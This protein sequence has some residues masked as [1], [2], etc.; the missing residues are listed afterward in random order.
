MVKLKDLINE[1]NG[2]IYH[3]TPT[4]QGYLGI[5]KNGLQPNKVDPN[6]YKNSK[7]FTPIKN[8][9][10]LTKEFGNA[11]RYSFMSNGSDDEYIDYLTFKPIVL[12]FGNCPPS[13]HGTPFASSISEGSNPGIAECI[14]HKLLAKTPMLTSQPSG[15]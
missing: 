12:T 5:L 11:V 10:Y 13:V 14:N 8:G 3:G 2:V 7:N 1:L 4:K 6:K 15:Y 9:V